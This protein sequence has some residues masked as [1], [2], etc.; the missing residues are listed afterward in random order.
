[1]NQDRS[2]VPYALLTISNLDS[3]N[4]DQ[5][6]GGRDGSFQVVGYEPGTY[7]VTAESG[8]EGK[9]RE[10]TVVLRDGESTEVE[11]VVE[12]T[13]TV[14]G[15]ITIGEI[16]VIAANIFAFPRDTTAPFIPQARTDESGFFEIA[17]PP[18][19]TIFDGL[20][21]HPAFDV[22]F[23]RSTIQHGKDL[24]IRTQQIGGTIVLEAK[25]YSSMLFHGGAELYAESL[26]N[27]AGGIVA[28]GR[29]TLPRLEPGHYTACTLDK[30]K[31][32]S[33][34]L[35]PHGTLTLSLPSETH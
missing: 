2:A 1:M 27:L 5:A 15:R 3:R 24:H 26:A 28:S 6:F 17:L 7:G 34:Y 20:V 32:V 31:C 8:P 9:S 11:L 19:T 22:M 10:T 35:P 4:S 21:I 29:I 33:G 14:R 23:G 16:P 18:G 13:E 30:G 12:K 25:P